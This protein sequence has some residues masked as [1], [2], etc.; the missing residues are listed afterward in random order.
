[1]RNL[2]LVSGVALVVVIS[3]TWYT[4]SFIREFEDQKTAVEKELTE[5]QDALRATNTTS[6]YKADKTRLTAARFPAYL[7]ARAAMQK[8]LA[9]RYAQP[10]S[11]RGFNAKR[12]RNAALRALA[13][14]LGKAK[15]SIDEF[16]AIRDRFAA[17]LATGEPSDLLRDWRIQTSNAKTLPK[18]LPLPTPATDA[19]AEEK[20]LIEKNQKAL[21]ESMGAELMEIWF[22]PTTSGGTMSS[23]G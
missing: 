21:A 15:M 9:E 17:I 11:R 7:Q 3:V 2:I 6:P 14:E 19:T 23:G 12:A 5:A 4:A 18:G 1:M 13:E 22:R 20:K 8:T 10:D 16:A